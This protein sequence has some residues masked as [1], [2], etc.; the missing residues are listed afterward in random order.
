MSEASA[1]VLGLSPIHADLAGQRRVIDARPIAGTAPLDT[2]G[3][4][5]YPVYEG[6]PD[7]QEA[8]FQKSELKRITGLLQRGTTAEQRRNLGFEAAG[9]RVAKDIPQHLFDPTPEE[10]LQT[11]LDDEKRANDEYRRRAEFQDALIRGRPLKVPVD[12]SPAAK[13]NATRALRNDF[14]RET[15]AARELAQAFTTMKTGYDHAIATGDQNAA[16]QAI[17]VTFQKILD[18]QSVVRESEYFRSASGQSLWD[19]VT[20]QFTQLMSGGAKFTP[21][22]VKD[23]LD[24]SEK[25]VRAQ[26]FF[27]DESK[28]QID[29]IADESGLNK[30][31]ITRDWSNVLGTPLTPYQVWLERQRGRR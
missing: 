13:F 10:L 29:V 8:A 12:M 21:E 11:K 7:Q 23:F 6:T 25:L 28:R 20:G 30:D 1:K 26:S 22:A 15:S 5:T 3:P 18:P 24:V 27:A 19:R 4:Q 14:I 2:S 16:Q 9:A 31:L 17:L